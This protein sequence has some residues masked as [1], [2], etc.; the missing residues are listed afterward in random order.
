MTMPMPIVIDPV[1]QFTALLTLFE[2]S[3]SLYRAGIGTFAEVE[4]AQ[5]KALD[6]LQMASKLNVKI[7][8]DVAKRWEVAWTAYATEKQKGAATTFA[9]GVT[10][11]AAGL[12]DVTA[13]SYNIFGVRI[14]RTIVVGGAIA[15]GLALVIRAMSG[16]RRR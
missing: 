11:A 2:K 8:F 16:G 4:Q 3:L 13:D 14:P 15:I 6:A 9:S 10:N 5:K 7:P 1:T 12:F